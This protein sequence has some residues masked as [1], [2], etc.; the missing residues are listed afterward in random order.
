MSKLPHA[1]EVGALHDAGRHRENDGEHEPEVAQGRL[2]GL[3]VEAL[4]ADLQP[5]FGHNTPTKRARQSARGTE[6]R[7]VDLATRL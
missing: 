4:V 5:R 6:P 3:G 1:R 7:D 2:A